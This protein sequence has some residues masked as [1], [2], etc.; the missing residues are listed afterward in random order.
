MRL[1]VSGLVLS[2]AAGAIAVSATGALFT[3][4]AT[5]GSNSFA[6]GT[7]D[8]STSPASA[9]FNVSGMA[10]GDVQYST[11]TI[12]NDGALELRYALA[13]STDEDVLAAQLDLTV[14]V[15]ASSCDASNIGSGTVLYGPADLGSTGETNLF[16]D[17]APGSQSGD[18]TIAAAASEIL[19]FKAELPSAT[20]NS[21]QG[22]SSTATF[23]TYAEQT[24]N[25][26]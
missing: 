12:S 17:S 5:A 6:S 1:A 22:L 9:V 15:G 18:R 10:P 4:S 2:S 26:S 23:T 3:D 21:F 7:L 14:V 13:S 16:G 20:G 8:A 19:C 24:A 25:N 11:L